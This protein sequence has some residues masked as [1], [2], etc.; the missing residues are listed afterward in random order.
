VIDIW[1]MMI[2]DTSRQKAKLIEKLLK[3]L[4][5]PN[6]DGT[7]NY[8]T[9]TD[10]ELESLD[11]IITRIIDLKF[12]TDVDFCNVIQFNLINRKEYFMPHFTPIPHFIGE[13]EKNIERAFEDSLENLSVAAESL[14]RISAIYKMMRKKQGD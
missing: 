1:R 4:D 13:H 14:Q 3:F 2:K 8:P 7:G 11:E 10:E 6:I 12:A 5:Q 9:V